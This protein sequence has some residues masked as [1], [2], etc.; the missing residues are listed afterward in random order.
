MC[1]HKQLQ[2]VRQDK[3][4]SCFA[5]S[6][7]GRTWP[8]VSELLL[9][10]LRPRHRDMPAAPRNV[11]PASQTWAIGDLLQALASLGL[12]SLYDPAGRVQLATR[13]MCEPQA[14]V[15]ESL[16][17]AGGLPME[18][19]GLLGELQGAGSP[20]DYDARCAILARVLHSAYRGPHSQCL[21]E[22]QHAVEV[23]LEVG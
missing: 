2:F 14:M 6:G 22:L 9:D 4:A 19:S 10:D 11:A 16:A 3:D 1:D 13:R 5:A 8:E 18:T 15:L 23:R 12:A 7:A 21:A 20:M 17:A